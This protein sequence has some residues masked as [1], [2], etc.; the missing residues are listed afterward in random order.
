MVQKTAQEYVELMRNAGFEIGEHDVKTSVPWWSLIDFGLWERM[1]LPPR[2]TEP[3]E[4]L[5][6]ARKP[7]K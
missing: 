2:K 4:I 7:L 3:T 5:T 1:G 6:V